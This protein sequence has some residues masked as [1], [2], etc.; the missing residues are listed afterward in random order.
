M[1]LLHE[2]QENEPFVPYYKRNF[3]KFGGRWPPI[4]NAMVELLHHLEAESEGSPLLC[5]TSHTTVFLQEVQGRFI[6]WFTY[7]RTFIDGTGGHE[8]IP[9]YFIQDVHKIVHRAETVDQ[10]LQ[11][12]VGLIRQNEV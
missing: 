8:N 6:C 2:C 4:I 5:G 1:K 7:G 3:G 9:A 11:I 10:A 12:I